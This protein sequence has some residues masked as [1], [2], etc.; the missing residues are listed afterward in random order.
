MDPVQHVNVQIV[1]ATCVF[2]KDKPK[3]GGPGR[4]KQCCER[5]K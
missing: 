3:F 1:V 5:K 4:R 2:C